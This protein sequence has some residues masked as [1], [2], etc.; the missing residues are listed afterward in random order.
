MKNRIDEG[1]SNR[2]I[3]MFSSIDW[4]AQ[5]QIHHH[6]AKSFT[7]SGN[8]VLFVE[9]TGVRTLRLNDFDRILSRIKNRAK[10]THGFS[11]ADENL[12][13][14]SPGFLP[15]PYSKIANSSYTI[16]SRLDRNNALSPWKRNAF[17][18]FCLGLIASAGLYWSASSIFSQVSLRE[19]AESKLKVINENLEKRVEDRTAELAKS[20]QNYRS[21]FE[22]AKDGIYLVNPETKTFVDVNKVGAERLGY[23]RDEII[24]QPLQLISSDRLNRKDSNERI[25][26]LLEDD[27]SKLSERIHLRKDGT[28]ILV[29]ISNAA[30]EREGQ[31]LIQSI[32]RDITDRKKAEEKIIK[33]SSAVEQNP[34]MVMITDKTGVIEYVNAKFTEL[35]GYTAAEAIGQ[36]PG[37]LK[38]G[39]TPPE[40][41]RELWKTIR[42]GNEWHGEVLDMHK[43]GTF[44]WVS[45][46]INPIKNDAGEIT[47]FVSME[48]DITERKKFELEMREAQENAEIANRAKS[49]FLANMSHE[50]RTPLNAIIG[51]ADVIKEETFGA[52]ANEKYLEY[53][54]DIKSSGQHLL[55]LINEVLDLSKIE[56][57]NLSLSIER[58][59]PHSLFAEALNLLQPL[60]DEKNLKFELPSETQ[61]TFVLADRG[62]L[63]QVALNLMSNAIKYNHK[64]GSVTVACKAINSKFIQLDCI[65]TGPGISPEDQSKLFEPFCRLGQEN[66]E[67][68]GTGIGLTVT[69]ELVEL[70]G[71]SIG[72]RSQMGEGSHFY[73]QLPIAENTDMS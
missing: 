23:F 9:N 29:E 37:L 17:L 52:L 67:V 60:L 7:D 33:L 64:S 12:Y 27:V 54:T 65:D 5:W 58:V 47:H 31:I 70:M 39:A 14:Y 4:S 34:S 63:K 38:S 42:D 1:I 35:S 41:Y 66:S 26:R 11:E 53:V 30:V 73:V 49:E 68:E 43:N 36:K 2:N 20:E 50:L 18:L 46:S 16:V 10:S 15:F 22:S 72:L 13:I 21:I 28:E 55:N 19:Y 59:S 32:A 40:T 71:G 24:G 57:G 25:E 44:F 8:R 61:D 51:F 3:I 69:K 56:S 62:R 45:A 6:L 48:E